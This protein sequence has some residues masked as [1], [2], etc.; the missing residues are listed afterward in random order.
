MP[1]GQPGGKQARKDIPLSLL[2]WITWFIT[3]IFTAG[4]YHK[5]KT[6]Q[7]C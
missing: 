1:V 3:A 7:V 5:K 2:I 4:L 6:R